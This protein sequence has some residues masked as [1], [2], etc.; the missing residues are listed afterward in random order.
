MKKLAGTYDRLVTGLAVVA[1]LMLVGVF[2]AV[3]ADVTLR[4]L[5]L[6]PPIWTSQVSEFVLLYATTLAAPWLLREKGHVFIT[7]FLDLLPGGIRR[8]INKGVYAAGALICLLIFVVSVEV[9][10]TAQGME[11]RTFAAPRWTVFVTMP[12]CFLLLT[13]EF[14]RYLVGRGSLYEGAPT[15]ESI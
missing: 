8:V 7:T 9:L 2:V 1:A 12:P 15:D 10:L 3:I 14:L 5:R 4:T 11:I 13:V 6:Q